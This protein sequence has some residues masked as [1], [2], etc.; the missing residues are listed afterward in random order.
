MTKRVLSW[1]LLVTA[2][3]LPGCPAA[4]PVAVVAPPA[5]P[6][7]APD[8]PLGLGPVLW[9]SPEE[10]PP[11]TRE[12]N[13]RRQRVFFGHGSLVRRS[14]PDWPRSLAHCPLQRSRETLAPCASF[15]LTVTGQDPDD[16][17]W[18]TGEAPGRAV[19]RT[20][21]APDP[22]GWDILLGGRDRVYAFRRESAL[23]DEISDTGEIRAFLAGEQ[24]FEWE[25]RHV[26]E[27][28]EKRMIV[29]HLEGHELQVAEALP[30]GP[31]QPRKLGP[32][33]R[34]DIVP[35]SRELEKARTAREIEEKK[36]HP[37]Y[38]PSAAIATRDDPAVK[39][40]WAL[41]WVEPLAP[42]FDWPAD[43]PHQRKGR[44]GCS[45]PPSRDLS[46]KS[47]EKRF[48]VTR[49]EGTRQLSDRVVLSSPDF[50]PVTSPLLVKAAARG[51]EINGVTYDQKGK[52]VETREVKTAPA[53][54]PE[55]MVRDEQTLVA[56]FDAARGQGAVVFWSGD[57]TFW[58]TFDGQGKPTGKVSPLAGEAPE[59]FSSFDPRPELASSRGGWWLSDRNSL[60]LRS[61]DRDAVVPG[62]E[63]RSVQGFFPDHDPPLLV[64]ID[65]ETIL[66]QRFDPVSGAH[67]AEAEPPATTVGGLGSLASVPRTHLD[68]MMLALRPAGQEGPAA[69]V[70]LSLSTGLWSEIP[71]AIPAEIGA[72]RGYSVHEVAGD[73]V[74]LV[75]GTPRLAAT[76]LKAGQTVVYAESFAASSLAP[77]ARERPRNA[78]RGPLLG[79]GAV[80]LPSR[81]GPLVE[82]PEL[83]QIAER[84]ECVLPT[85]PG[86]LTLLC[87]E[88]IDK[89]KAGTRA[90][91]QSYH[92][93]DD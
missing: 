87:T 6:R 55:G 16:E 31:G 79:L 25:L 9:L 81:P 75:K 51:V 50:D 21:S 37:L 45:R 17:S 91:I 27:V 54:A 90:G 61:L 29:G 34:L 84:C 65:D 3:L 63:K 73:V 85:A 19:V 40:G 59:G 56:A 72:P 57:R 7:P 64:T 66:R 53:L 26:V 49:F 11:S 12:F 88:A 93:R 28:G 77:L 32:A 52:A 39:E 62:S 1:G 68:P 83:A 47:V 46:V 58:R 74:V 92:F 15:T 41:V 4:S 82:T 18:R 20:T 89:E 33:T 43:R 2:A 13:L 8:V 86:T 71:G 69:L 70:R 78:L 14:F 5:G 48:H 22:M 35:I 10:A 23:V 80:M 38:G 67:A 30:E 76:W 44:H 42:P 24:L 60:R 36:L